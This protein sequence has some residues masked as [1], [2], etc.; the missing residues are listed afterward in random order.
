[1]VLD[2]LA[3]DNFDFTRKIVKKNLS[4]K[5]VK[6]LGFFFVKTEFLDKNLTFRIEWSMMTRAKQILI[7]L[8]LLHVG[9]R[10]SQSSNYFRPSACHT[11]QAA[12]VSFNEAASMHQM[13][14]I[15]TQM[16]FL[17]C[18][19]MYYR[20]D[21]QCLRGKKI[22]LSLRSPSAI[23]NNDDDCLGCPKENVF[24]CALDM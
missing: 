7:S 14:R 24:G 17:I 15:S 3:V 20:N 8:L 4:E 23:F 5:L 1:M 11:N 9:M 18:S 22:R 2:F 21:D 13:P 16:T 10:L 12:F 6:M 19:N